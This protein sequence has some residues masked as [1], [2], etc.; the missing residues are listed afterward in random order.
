[1]YGLPFANL[2]TS[3]FRK[4]ARELNFNLRVDG[5]RSKLHFTSSFEGR[6]PQQIIFEGYTVMHVHALDMMNLHSIPIICNLHTFGQRHH[7]SRTQSGKDQFDFETGNSNQ[8]LH[9]GSVNVRVQL[10]CRY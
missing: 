6:I 1:M 8:F 3:S 4:R 7:T 2:A 5:N 10:G 9:A